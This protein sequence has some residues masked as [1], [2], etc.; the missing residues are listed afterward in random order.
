MN[1]DSPSIT[2][3]LTAA[4]RAVHAEVDGEPLILDD[5]VAF[6]VSLATRSPTSCGISGSTPPIR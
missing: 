3:F 4:A 6:G 5:P 2:A 1:S